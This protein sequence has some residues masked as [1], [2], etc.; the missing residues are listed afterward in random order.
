M[1]PGA[2]CQSAIELLD[3]IH[4]ATAPADR[5]IRGWFRRRRYAGSGD[6]AAIR[7]WVYTVLRRQ[8]QLDWW[9]EGQ[10]GHG[11]NRGRVLAALMLV[12]GWSVE[13]IGSAFDG[14]QYRPAAL[15]AGEGAMV[16]ALRG[17]TLD[18]PDQPDLVAAN[19]PKVLADDLRDSLG[20]GISGELSAFLGE[21]TVD[22]RVNTLKGDR[23][24]VL[25]ALAREGIAAE[26]TMLSPLGLRLAGRAPITGG[27]A[28]K[29]GLVELQ[30]EGSQVI[31]LLVGA[32]AGSS[33][34]DFC[35]GAGGKSLAL[36]AAMENR[37]RIVA[38]D[39]DR[40]RLDRAAPR[41]DRAGVAIVE[42]R[43]LDGLDDPWISSQ[44][45]GFDRVLIDAPCSQMGAWRRNPESRWRLTAGEFAR[46]RALQAGLLDAAPR[47]VGVGG[48]LVYATCSLLR[49]ENED[50]VAGFLERDGRGWRTVPAGD[51]WRETIGG[52][53][54][55]AVGEFL[56]LT[57]RQHGTDGFFAAILERVR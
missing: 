2:R 50:Q 5:V 51:A 20:D 57:P 31:A 15:G 40:A 32:E 30:D 38:C 24:A 33:V 22:L 8:R 23:P 47:L 3:A 29:S 14:G 45:G 55:A 37:G 1:T 16:A 7:A 9:I 19:A 4:G 10:G 17:R 48:R 11:D 21:A 27:N 39:V 6:R 36:A 35:A 42:P 43:L 13:E 54:P 56:H 46:L 12:E 25:A 52:A 18:N 53:G 28:Y 34:V 26:A 44:A 41:L 49:R